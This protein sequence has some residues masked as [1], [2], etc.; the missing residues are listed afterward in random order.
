M[1]V[2]TAGLEYKPELR[3]LCKF[4]LSMVFMAYLDLLYP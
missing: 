1:G 3:R 4:C 2:L